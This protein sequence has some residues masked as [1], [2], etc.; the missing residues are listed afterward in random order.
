V[1]ID[2]STGL[3]L[4]DPQTQATIAANNVPGVPNAGPPAGG[5]GIPHG[6]AEIPA[7]PQVTAPPPPAPGGP[8][9]TPPVI[10]SRPTAPVAALSA[11]G[12]TAPS[13]TGGGPTKSVTDQEK[14]TSST[15][16]VIS[17]EERKAESDYQKTLGD[18][19]KVIQDAGAIE[20]EKARAEQDAAAKKEALLQQHQEKFK[21]I[22]DGANTEYARA[23]ANVQAAEKAYKEAKPEGL[24]ADDKYGLRRFFAGVAMA[25]GGYN[26]G[27]NGGPNQGY[28]MIKDAI[29]R[30][31]RMER[32]RIGKLKEGADEARSQLSV[33]LGKKHEALGDLAAWKAAAWDTAAAQLQT[34]LAA[35]GM[36][37]A[38]VQ[39]DARVLQ[40]KAEAQKERQTFLQGTRQSITNQVQTKTQQIV[41][42]A[43][44]TKAAD[45]PLSEWK[46]EE[47]KAEGF[48]MRAYKSNQEMESSAYSSKD[49]EVLRNDALLQAKGGLTAAGV[50]RLIGSTYQRLS[51]EGKKRFNATKEFITSALRP[52]SGAVIGPSEIADAEQRYGTQSGDTPEAARQKKAFRMNKVAEIGL[53]TGRPGFWMDQ[54]GAYGGGQGGAPSKQ[55]VAKPQSGGLPPGAIAG[56]LKGVRGYVLNGQFVA[57]EMAQR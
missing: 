10:P 48:A 21:G 23:E 18:Q 36:P 45:K 40:A 8:A 51:P 15:R 2:P 9:L 57:Q 26:A 16:Q 12:L 22:I 53:Q 13:L 27:V 38:Q 3:D 49:L 31:D 14:T 24:F 43:T 6:P 4:D 46:P 25:L 5:L 42:G 29:D 56:T 19:S 17:K 35:Q 30:K 41:G 34:R 47:R 11:P 32:E 37:A 28:V 7:P 39:T 1:N 54:T 33:V 20:Q 55:D 52:E 50:Q 44:G